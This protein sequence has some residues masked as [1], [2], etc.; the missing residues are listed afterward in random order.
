MV[1]LEPV[2]ILEN[3]SLLIF[4]ETPILGL[5]FSTLKFWM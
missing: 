4:L 1:I 5:S 3:G 2:P